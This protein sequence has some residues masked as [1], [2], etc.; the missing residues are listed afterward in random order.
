FLP[1][2]AYLAEH[3]GWRSASVAVG[4]GALA[5][6]PL[7]AL[8]LRNAP[9]DLGLTPYGAP[10]DT[11]VAPPT[12]PANPVRTALTVPREAA[13]TRPFWLLAG[14]FA[15]CGAT[16][17]G[18]IGTHLIPAAH[19]HGVTETAAAGLLAL[20]GVFDVAGTLASGWLTDRVDPRRL[21]LWYYG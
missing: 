11:P 5:G 2:L 6:L 19:D 17:N 14:S 4:V 21:L 10:P 12:P 20:V 7:V 13:R 16:T 8:F 15:I 9:A 18:L 3:H 1:L